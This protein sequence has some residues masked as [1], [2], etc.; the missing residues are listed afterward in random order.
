MDNTVYIIGMVVAIGGWVLMRGLKDANSQPVARGT[1][2][3]PGG[4]QY[5][6][7]RSQ[8][9]PASSSYGEYRN[10]QTTGGRRKTIN[11]NRNRNRSKKMNTRKEKKRQ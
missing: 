6:A 10:Q 1:T 9:P 7:D 2:S 5:T 3:N 8:M 11:K 4:T